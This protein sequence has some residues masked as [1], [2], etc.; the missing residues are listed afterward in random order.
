MDFMKLKNF[1]NITLPFCALILSTQ[2]TAQPCGSEHRGV[3]RQVITPSGD[4][5]LLHTDL[6]GELSDMYEEEKGI[7]FNYTL[8]NS[9]GEIIIDTMVYLEWP[10]MHYD[11]FD[12]KATY[13]NHFKKDEIFNNAYKKE[14]DCAVY[15]FNTNFDDIVL[16]YSLGGDRRH[17]Y[18]ITIKQNGEIK[19]ILHNF[20]ELLAKLGNTNSLNIGNDIIKGQI[21]NTYL[22]EKSEAIKSL[23]RTRTVHDTITNTYNIK[24]SSIYLTQIET[25]EKSSEIRPK[26][27]V[28]GDNWE[29]PLKGFVIDYYNPPLISLNEKVLYVTVFNDDEE[30]CPGY[31]KDVYPYVYAIDVVSGEVLWMRKLGL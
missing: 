23:H 26:F 20:D 17:I 11:I 14:N 7:Y 21:F 22:N 13:S 25:K 29:V 9:V 15:V 8:I 24:Y 18:E 16:G 27:K 5:L 4:L 6:G 30:S 12:C 3:D 19:W 31:G 2:L 10:G 28:V 1:K